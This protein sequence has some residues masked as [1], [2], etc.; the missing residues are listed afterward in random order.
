[1]A[2]EV[3]EGSWICGGADGMG[4]AAGKG[5]DGAVVAGKAKGSSSRRP[6]A[7]GIWHLEECWREPAGRKPRCRR[8]RFWGP[9]FDLEPG[10]S[11]AR[12]LPWAFSSFL[13][14]ESSPSLRLLGDGEGDSSGVSWRS[15][16][17]PSLPWSMAWASVTSMSATA[18]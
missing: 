6:M 12:F 11:S 9:P 1:M 3:G 8:R 14:M 10:D 17:S 5:P 16:S 4:F 18:L 15:S 2:S 7:C 13:E